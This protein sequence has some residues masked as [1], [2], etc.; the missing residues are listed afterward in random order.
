MVIQCLSVDQLCK[1]QL[2]ELP[3]IL[4]GFYTSI[5]SDYIGVEVGVVGIHKMVVFL[6]VQAEHCQMVLFEI[7]LSSTRYHK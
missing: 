2:V 1:G 6:C 5:T 4:D 3:T 7:Y